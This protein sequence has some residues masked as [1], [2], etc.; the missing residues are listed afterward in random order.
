MINVAFLFLLFVVSS[1]GFDIGQSFD[2]KYLSSELSYKTVDKNHFLSSNEIRNGDGFQNAKKSNLG[3][4]EEKVT[5]SRLKLFNSSKTRKTIYI[6]SPLTTTNFLDFYLF[7]KDFLDKNL[8]LGDNRPKYEREIPNHF[9]TIKISLE[10]NEEALLVS[11]YY[12][13]QGRTQI[14]LIAM[15]EYSFFSFIMLDMA[16][17]GFIISGI[18]LIIIFQIFFYRAFKNEYFKYYLTTSTVILGYLISYNGFFYSIF[19]PS[20]L[21]DMLVPIFG[22]AVLLFYVLFLD[23]FLGF[24][25]L[26][27]FHQNTVNII[28]AYTIVLAIGGLSSIFSDKFVTADNYYFMISICIVIYLIFLTYKMIMSSDSMFGK[29]YLIGQFFV[30]FG[31]SFQALNAIGI[32]PTASY[33]QQIL[34]FTVLCEM[35]FFSYAI[36]NLIKINIDEKENNQKLLIAQSHFSSI[37]SALRCITHQWKLPIAR[38]GQTI[39]LIKTIMKFENINSEKLETSLNE[40]YNNLD[41]LTKTVNDFKS[42]YT[43]EEKISMVDIYEIIN[44][45]KI[46]IAEKAAEIDAKIICLQSDNQIKFYSD[47]RALM[48]ISLIIIDN[49]LEIAK[50]RKISKPSIE[51]GTAFYNTDVIITFRDNCGGIAQ[52]PIESIFE[53]GITSFHDDA[54]RGNGLS[55]AKM[56]AESRINSKLSVKNT[57]NGARFKLVFNQPKK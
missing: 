33:N 10:P 55:I 49:F 32:V 6:Y 5:Y 12:H 38:I 57:E 22:Y 16:V 8:H 29:Y 28:Y 37:G 44:E 1:F 14:G 13:P 15:E 9:N 35:F 24:R 41:Y 46:L 17:W 34:G 50:L 53:V 30:L 43:K 56:I 36:T 2:E 25:K 20:A 48:Q 40:M 27:K 11:K 45:V 4:L 23:K 19:G 7:K 47:N 21:N 51:I 52:N 42:F 39:T 3:F 54:S 26:S 31:Y 18:V